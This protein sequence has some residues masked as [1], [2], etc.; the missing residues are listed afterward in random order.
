M[1]MISGLL[2]AGEANDYCENP[3]IEQQP[4][5]SAHHGSSDQVLD[6]PAH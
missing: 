3:G 2:R 1:I 5:E 4:T 6:Y